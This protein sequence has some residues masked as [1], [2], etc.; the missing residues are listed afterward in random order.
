M[1]RGRPP[2]HPEGESSN[3]EDGSVLAHQLGRYRLVA[4]LGQGGMGT[5]WLAVAGGLGEFRKLLVVKELRQDLTRNHRFVG[6]FLDEAKIA[7]R[8]SHP[9]VV[10]TLEAGQEHERYFLAMEFLDGQPLSDVLQRA[11]KDPRITLGVR[12][13]ILCDAL[14]GLHYAHELRDYD[15]TDLQ[16]VHRDI[17]PHNIFVTY[18]GQVKV[19]DFG[20]AKAADAGS[21]T[22][23]G[24]FKGR[25]AYASPEQIKG[26]PVDRRADIFA[27]GVVLWESVAVKR[28]AKGKPS[29]ESLDARLAGAEPRLSQALPSIEPLLAEICDRA[30]EV[31]PGK[32]YATAEELRLA[33]EQYL[34]VSGERVDTA[35]IAA[36]MQSAF[37][38]ERATMHRMIHNHLKEA[39]F[40]ES[41]VRR[42]EPALT[43]AL[44]GAQY[45]PT[46]VADLSEL[47]Q[48]SRTDP[49]DGQHSADWPNALR[50]RTRL[51][52]AAGIGLLAIA[53][54][55]AYALL[56]ER[57]NGVVTTPL[58]AA[59]TQPTPPPSAPEAPA[60]V[61]DLAAAVAPR[62]PAAGT[63]APSAAPRELRT[64]SD[65]QGTL[66]RAPA[67]SARPATQ[68]ARTP[69][70][71][72]AVRVGA[73]ATPARSASK[74]GRTPVLDR[75]AQAPDSDET[76]F[77]VRDTDAP[78]KPAG[79]AAS[80]AK[81]ADDA[82]A[83]GYGQD[84]RKLRKSDRRPLDM[85]DP[86]R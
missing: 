70:L 32:R 48:S 15:G 3:M 52:W 34:F 67:E 56:A 17:S 16:I 61:D 12:L 85:E 42:L 72:G 7:A 14:A 27:M 71:R 81:A 55:V 46:T 73:A 84:L 36:V 29:Q 86:F 18:D 13:R 1:T 65:V 78:A 39:D 79:T 83:T 58:P 43:R 77:E 33:L 54:L 4:T 49:G 62:G 31:E 19:V 37:A 66:Q 63:A 5:I 44:Q 26:Q 9:N 53:G 68:D 8:L 75:A 69:A 11:V 20:I 30:M 82:N 6:M 50:R 28:F 45:D 24:V 40:S 38:A 10:Q 60:N 47:A 23:P 74:Q 64:Q 22:Q 59:P 21:F 51:A 2:E 25:F 76:V 35:V 57:S 80:V 41:L